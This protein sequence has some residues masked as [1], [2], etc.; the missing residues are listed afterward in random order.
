MTDT[1]LH[2]WEVALVKNR[3]GSSPVDVATTLIVT[4]ATTEM[5]RTAIEGSTLCA[6][7]WQIVVVRRLGLAHIP[8]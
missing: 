8:F 6:D 3:E 7:G 4:A 1:R 5:V 2:I